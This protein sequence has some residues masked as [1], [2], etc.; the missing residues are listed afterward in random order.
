MKRSMYSIVCE[1]NVT[2]L[3]SML[4]RPELTICLSEAPSAGISNDPT[5]VVTCI[6]IFLPLYVGRQAGKKLNL[7]YSVYYV[8]SYLYF[9]TTDKI[10]STEIIGSCSQIYHR[11]STQILCAGKRS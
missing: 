11:E 6:L 3:N 7:N 10:P 5:L 1:K 2:L 8:T 4:H 9:P